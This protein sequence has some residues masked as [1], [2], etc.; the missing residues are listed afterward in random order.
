MNISAWAAAAISAGS[1][2]AVKLLESF[3]SFGQ[4]KLD[5]ASE[6]RKELRDEVR[7]L[8]GELREQRNKMHE[9]NE[10]Y[11]ELTLKNVEITQKYA[12][13]LTEHNALKKNHEAV[14]KELHELKIKLNQ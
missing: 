12:S 10:K 8:Q 1:V 6:I 2:V 13:L 11:Y 7:A 4:K 9:Y 3:T 14:V 5:D